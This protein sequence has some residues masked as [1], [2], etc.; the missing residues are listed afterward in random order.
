[1][2]ERKQDDKTETDRGR[3]VGLKS[4]YGIRG[5]ICKEYG[6]TW[7]YLHFGIAWSIVQRILSDA[8]GYETGEKVTRLTEKNKNS[9]MNELNNLA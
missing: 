7:E 2:D 5:S 4:P 9:I 1:M 6:W 3:T 8:P